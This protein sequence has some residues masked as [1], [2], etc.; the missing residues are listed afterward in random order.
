MPE[1]PRSASAAAEHDRRAAELED[2]VRV[3]Q[4]LVAPVATRCTDHAGG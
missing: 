3:L 1:L 4:D 2:Q